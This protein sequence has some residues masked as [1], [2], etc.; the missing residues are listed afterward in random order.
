MYEC[1]WW[2]NRSNQPPALTGLD[3]PSFST[4]FPNSAAARFLQEVVVELLLRDIS[5]LLEIYLRK[6][7]K[8]FTRM[9]FELE[10]EDDD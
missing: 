10:E 4:Y 7:R 6:M 1:E 3:K 5:T 8:S 9:I 2:V